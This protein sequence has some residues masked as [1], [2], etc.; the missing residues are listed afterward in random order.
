MIGSKPRCNPLRRLLNGLSKIPHRQAPSLICTYPNLS[1]ANNIT[2]SVRPWEFRCKCWVI[3]WTK[4]TIPLG[5]VTL[6]FH[7]RMMRQQET[8]MR[9]TISKCNPALNRLE[10]NDPS[11]LSL[12]G[13]NVSRTSSRSDLLFVKHWN[14]RQNNPTK[15]VRTSKCKRDLWYTVYRLFPHLFSTKR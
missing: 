5:E 2:K 1:E 13:T 14:P 10:W 11:H 3:Q 15:T 8:N 7:G 6:F 4:N 12:F 9:A